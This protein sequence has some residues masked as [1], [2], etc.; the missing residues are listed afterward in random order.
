MSEARRKRIEQEL[1]QHTGWRRDPGPEGRLTPARLR[2]LAALDHV[3]GVHPVVQHHGR[4]FLGDRSTYTSLTGVPG[5][6][7]DGLRRRL[8]VGDLPGA[9]DTSGVAV[10][11]LLLYRLGVVD[12]ADVPGVLGRELTFEVRIGDQPQP[13]F[14]LRLL[15][16]GGGQVR[17]S[18]ENLLDKVL[19]RLPGSLEQMGLTPQ[20]AKAVR[21]MI[22]LAKQS[23]TK[24]VVIR[25]GYTVRGVLGPPDDQDTRRRSDRMLRYAELLL[26][27]AAAEA[28]HL[29][30][31][32]GRTN[33][34]AEV[35]LEVD[36]MDHVKA[37]QEAVRGLGFEA[38]SAVEYIEREQFTYVVA[39]TGMSAVALIALIVAAIGITNTMLM[40]VLERVREIGIMKATGARDGHILMLFLTE[41]ALIGLVGGLLGLAGARGFAVPADAWLRSAVAKRLSVELD[42]SLFAFPWWL[43]VGAPVFAVLV[44]TLAAWYPARRAVRT[45]PVQAL[46]HE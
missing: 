23:P 43:V 39:L 44:T 41:G 46:R 36:D 29:R 34:F 2:D 6:L 33:G 16:G 40:S 11:E 42:G 13:G 17:L 5:E 18:E 9:D 22:A 3:V 27:P 8:L 15:T 37:V 21:G 10:S 20:E 31:P 38:H 4:G 32:E 26:S 19:Q 1:R 12:E 28:F 35:V 24:P 14:L 25:A 30:L 45:D 7:H